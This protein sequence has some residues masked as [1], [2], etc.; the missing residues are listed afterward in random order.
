MYQG[1]RCALH[2]STEPNLAYVDNTT[3]KV[4]KRSKLFQISQISLTLQDVISSLLG[5]KTL[6]D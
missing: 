5:Q 6:S 2:V 1:L 3:E 4:Q